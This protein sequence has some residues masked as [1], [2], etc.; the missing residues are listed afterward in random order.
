MGDYFQPVPLIEELEG[1]QLRI[2]ISETDY[3][4]I[5][6]GKNRFDMYEASCP[7]QVC[8][9]EGEVTLADRETRL[10]GSYIICMPNGLVLEMRSAEE[11]LE[12]LDTSDAQAPEVEIPE[13]MQNADETAEAANEEKS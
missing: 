3:N 6:V 11:L 2:K 12:L 5:E 9:T 4:I 1:Q 10:L 13:E 7:D 8:I